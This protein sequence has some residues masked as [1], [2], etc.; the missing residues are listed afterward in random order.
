MMLKPGSSTGIV[1][2][3]TVILI[4][5]KVCK[6]TRIALASRQYIQIRGLD[7]VSP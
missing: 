7:W 4:L 6:L 5:S 2:N 3:S 1:E